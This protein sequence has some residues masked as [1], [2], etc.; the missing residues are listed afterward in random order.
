MADTRMKLS[1][2][3]GLGTDQIKNKPC[4]HEVYKESFSENGQSSSLLPPW[5]GV[6]TKYPCVI[7][8]GIYG[9]GES[10]QQ[11]LKTTG[12]FHFAM[13]TAVLP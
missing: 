1:K 8:D 11:S 10:A 13:Q 6:R 5:Q 7:L 2:R 12:N 3:T 9:E 4:N